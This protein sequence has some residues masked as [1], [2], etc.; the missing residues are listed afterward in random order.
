MEFLALAIAAI[1]ACTV[2][3]AM[4]RRREPKEP[5]FTAPRVAA[6]AMTLEALVPLGPH[7]VGSWWIL[8]AILVVMIALDAIVLVSLSAVAARVGPA[9]AMAGALL[10]SVGWAARTAQAMWSMVT[11]IDWMR[12]VPVPEALS[13]VNGPVVEAVGAIGGLVV[14]CALGLA[15]SDR[16]PRWAIA[17]LLV[18]N[19]TASVLAMRVTHQLRMAADIDGITALSWQRNVLEAIAAVALASVLWLYR[20][21][22]LRTGLPRAVGRARG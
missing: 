15:I 10:W 1:V 21:Q 12:E 5:T 9:W 22:L 6:I 14:G 17:A 18:T 20:R 19:A 7:D 4:I 11:V 8:V 13:Q 16:R 2:V 3:L